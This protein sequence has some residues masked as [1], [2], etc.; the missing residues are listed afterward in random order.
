MILLTFQ[1]RKS[2]LIQIATRS[3]KLFLLVATVKWITKTR[4]SFSQFFVRCSQKEHIYVH[5]KPCNFF[6][7]THFLDIFSS[8]DCYKIKREIIRIRTCLESVF[9]KI[10][11]SQMCEAAACNAVVFI[12]FDAFIAN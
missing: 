9:R 3:S 4:T 6:L 5:N 2:A 12:A 11:P 8:N 10:P 7:F 1:F